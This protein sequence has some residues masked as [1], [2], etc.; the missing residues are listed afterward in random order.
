MKKNYVFPVAAV[1]LTMI[2]T[3]YGGGSDGSGASAAD[4]AASPSKVADPFFTT[5]I[6]G[7]ETSP[8]D[9]EPVV[10]DVLPETTPEDTEPTPST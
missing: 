1:M 4:K 5:V 2:L 10:A 9:T 3:A 8:E 7:I 6:N